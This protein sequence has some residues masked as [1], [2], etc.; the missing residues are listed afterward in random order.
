MSVVTKQ[1]SS[2]IL[3]KYPCVARRRTGDRVFSQDI[4]SDITVVVGGI[5]YAL[6]KFPLVSLSGKIRR[7]VAESKD[8][9]Q[10][11]IEL[12]DLPGG[13]EAFEFAA[14]FCYG[15]KFE[16]DTSN[17]SALRCA[18]EYLDMSEEYAEENLAVR[19]EAYLSE[20]VFNNLQ[21]CVAVLQAC[22]SLLP[23]AEELGIVSRC[24]ESAAAKACREQMSPSLS[25]SDLSSSGWMDIHVSPA[26]F[27]QTAPAIRRSVEWWIED[28]SVLRIDSFQRVISAMKG[29]GLRSDSLGAA[30]AHYTQRWLRGLIRKQASVRPLETG[31]RSKVKVQ[32]VNAAVEH[33]QRILVETLV[34][35]LPVQRNICSVSLLSALL[36]VANNLDTTIASR[37]DLER[38]IGWQLEQATVD[39]LLIPSCSY[40]NGDTFFDLDTISRIV[41]N[42]LNQD[43]RE[44]E[45]KQDDSLA[46]YNYDSSG[47]P[48]QSA[49]MKAARVLDRCLAEIAPDANF[50]ISKF[51]AFAEL[52]PEY[53]RVVDDG[54]YRAVD[55]YLKAHPG[56]NEAERKKVCSLMNCQ[57]LSQEACSH[58]AQNERLPVQVVVQVLYFEQMR[59][60]N[61]MQG[62]GNVHVDEKVMSVSMAP[63]MSPKGDQ[64]SVMQRQNRELIKV[65]VSKLMIS[66]G[67]GSLEEEQQLQQVHRQATITKQPDVPIA[68]YIKQYGEK[69]KSRFFQSFS[70][71]LNK[72]NPFYRNSSNDNGVKPPQ[73]PDVPPPRRSRRYSLS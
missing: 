31:S 3:I 12:P 40:S 36:R 67:Q 52:M 50:S 42:F 33:E 13:A 49:V 47:S 65:E 30:I 25:R 70:K 54:L 63:A 72:L 59:L 41:M 51:V 69:P 53:A 46:L 17:V 8:S 61:A 57:K 7:I 71:K 64:Y 58:A 21:S 19:A 39:D 6:H 37:L 4:P 44:E 5:A 23:V 10:S 68:G 55:I 9:D 24:V 43:G 56:L 38:R 26:G 35:L 27:S 28:L 48:P 66:G 73:T 2:S 60:R 32:D 62:S 18:A 14:K 29:R 34:S 45:E 22:E 16:I 20:V 15:I 11:K 1:D